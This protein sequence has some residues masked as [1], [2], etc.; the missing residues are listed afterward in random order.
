M[1]V[2]VPVHMQGEDKQ[3]LFIACPNRD[4]TYECKH[5][6]NFMTWNR[7]GCGHQTVV[8]INGAL[9]CKDNA[10]CGAFNIFDNTFRCK[11]H[12]VLYEPDYGKVVLMYA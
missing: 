8:D 10:S 1:E 11:N 9:W 2:V 5:F 3:I 6:G 4:C 7:D 12:S